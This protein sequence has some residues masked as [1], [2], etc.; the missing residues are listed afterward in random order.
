MAID[1]FPSA[2]LHWEE[3]V[4]FSIIPHNQ[5]FMHIDKILWAAFSPWGW[6]VPALSAS[7]LRLTLQSFSHLHCPPLDL[8]PPPSCSLRTGLRTSDVFHPSWV[9]GKNHLSQSTGSA[10]PDAALDIVGCISARAHCW[11]HSV[12]GSSGPKEQESFT[13]LLE[14][15][16]VSRLWLFQA[17]SSQQLRY[18][19]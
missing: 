8:L 11:S 12:W 13:P 5:T 16:K 4:S 15:Q 17:G 18:S 14:S 2:G 19:S 3:S 7:P 1:S 6:T 9:E 10:L